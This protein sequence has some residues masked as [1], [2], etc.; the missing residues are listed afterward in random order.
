M[1]MHIIIPK[2]TAFMVFA[3]GSYVINDIVSYTTYQGTSGKRLTTYK[4]VDGNYNGNLRAII[5]T[6][7]KNKKFSVNSIYQL[8][9]FFASASFP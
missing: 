2:Q 5:N 3:N 4:N 9:V 8:N 6:P 1:H 7:L